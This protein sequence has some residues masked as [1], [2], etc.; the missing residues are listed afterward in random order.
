MK[1]I[2][3][4]ILTLIVIS[5]TIAFVR[6]FTKEHSKSVVIPVSLEEELAQK[7]EQAIGK[8]A[9]DSTAW[10]QW[11][12]MGKRHFI[13]NKKEGW[14]QVTY[15]S[16]KILLNLNN[17]SDGLAYRNDTL[18]EGEESVKA[19]EFAWAAFCNDSFWLNAPSKLRDP[20]VVLEAKGD[21]ALLVSYTSGGVTPGD[22]YLWYMDKNGLPV[23]YTMWVGDNPPEAGIPTSWEAWITTST[24]AKIA[25]RH[26]IN[27]R[28]LLISK[29][30]GEMSWQ[31]LGLEADP[32]RE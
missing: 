17:L 19:L 13:W 8:A 1:K 11:T 21:T 5:A 22:E 3:R 24:G 12:F 31:S 7:M 27:G 23:S 20:G 30:K 10:V 6:F 9:W 25:T 32:F 16:E 2:N 18:L 15:G 26:D 14:L 4:L 28:E 29:V